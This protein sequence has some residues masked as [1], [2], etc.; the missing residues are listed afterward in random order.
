MAERF[1]QSV[2]DRTTHRDAVEIIAYVDDDD[3]GSHHLD[4]R[5]IRV[6]RII[7]PRLAMGEY[8]N[9]CLERARGDIVILVNDDIVIR[10]QGWDERIRALDAEY[11]D[12][13]Y[14][15]YANDLIQG[16]KLCTFPILSRRTC[17]VLVDPYPAV[18]RGEFIDTH[19]LDIFK[20]L[21]YRGYD[22][23]RYLEDVVF[24]H[25]HYGVGKAAADETY[26]KRVSYKD[27]PRFLALRERRQ[28]A[29]SRLMFAVQG[30]NL[31]AYSDLPSR[32]VSPDSLMGAMWLYTGMFLLDGNLPLRW[33]FSL[34]LVFFRHFVFAKGYSRRFRRLFKVN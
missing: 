30:K 6:D 31:P 10:T 21:R 15:G 14:L 7:G 27:S 9:R 19:I 3:I 29:A 20:R 1:F 5:D 33:R 28:E 4:S 24:E 12:K 2:V 25:M 23:I 8:N 13:V 18:Y 26:T 34:W 22:R 16:R 17:E 11:S 32:D